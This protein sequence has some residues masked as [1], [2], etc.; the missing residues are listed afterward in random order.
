MKTKV[1][2]QSDLPGAS[3]NETDGDTIVR[4]VGLKKSFGKIAMK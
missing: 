3:R 4:I 1:R 2:E